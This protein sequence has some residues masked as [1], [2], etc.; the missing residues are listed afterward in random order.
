MSLSASDT[1]YGE[2]AES[3]TPMAVSQYLAVTKPWELESREE[4]VREIWS[5]PDPQGE[6]RGRIMLPL[7]TDYVDFH[8]RFSD[9][10]RALGRINEWDARELEQH[11]I[12]T[13]ADLFFVQLNQVHPDETIP[14]KQAEATIDAIYEL[15]KAAAITAAAPNRTQRGGRLP[16]VVS[17]FL[18]EDVRLGHTK[19]GSFVFTVVS[20]LDNSSQASEATPTATPADSLFPRKVMET[21]ARGLQTT[22]DLAQGEAAAALETPAQ[23]G[24]SAGLLE[25]LEDIAEPEGLRSLRLFFEWAATESKPDVGMEPIVLEHAQVGDLARVRERLL[26]QD[27]SPHRETIFGIVMSLARED[28]SLEADEA[29]SVVLSAEVNGRKRNVHMT[30]SGTDHDRAIEAYRRK[31]PLIVTGDLVFERRAWRLVGDLE[32]DASIV[33]RG[34]PV[35]AVQIPLPPDFRLEQSDIDQPKEKDTER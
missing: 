33:E 18:D 28:D 29:G 27:E 11:I 7:A 6:P 20:R 34:R 26:R 2:V 5:L 31:L 21:L 13:R 35:R 32:V 24:L 16:G 22:R 9:A 14:L 4:H 8:A 15:L 23:W 3:L 12:A 17:A 30:M 1:A 25:S 10:L 19:R